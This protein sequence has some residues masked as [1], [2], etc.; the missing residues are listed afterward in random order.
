MGSLVYSV[1]PEVA[2]SLGVSSTVLGSFF[3][4]E[5]N[6]CYSD[7][8]IRTS[9][10]TTG[11]SS[12]TVGTSFMG[13]SMESIENLH[14]VESYIQSLSKAELE[15]LAQ[16]LTLI[17]EIESSEELIAEIRLQTIGELNETYNE[18]EKIKKHSIWG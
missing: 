7:L 10:L 9:S 4:R 13:T 15:T 11:L 18:I 16:E 1:K 8:D 2:I 6:N 12:A 17:N 3:A 5:V 14:E